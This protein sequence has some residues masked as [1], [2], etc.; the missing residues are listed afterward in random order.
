MVREKLEVKVT[1]ILCFRPVTFSPSCWDLLQKKLPHIYVSQELCLRQLG[2]GEVAREILE[3]KLI[4]VLRLLPVMFS[5]R[6]WDL[7]QNKL[8]HKYVSQE[9]C[10]RQSGQGEVALEKLECKVTLVLCFLPAMF[11]PTC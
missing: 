3:F 4:L 8:L 6:C 9:P 11:S 7:L 10:P 5:P 2:Q 1:L